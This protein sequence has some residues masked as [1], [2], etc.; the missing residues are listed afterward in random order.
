MCVPCHVMHK[1][2]SEMN[3][4]SEIVFDFWITDVVSCQLTLSDLY[5]VVIMWVQNWVYHYKQQVIRQ[6]IGHHIC[7]LFIIL[8]MLVLLLIIDSC[9]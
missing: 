6:D 4:N 2:S 5:F 9:H 1:Y 7:T 3:K 8:C